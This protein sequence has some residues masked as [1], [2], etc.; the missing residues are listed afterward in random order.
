MLVGELSTF[1]HEKHRTELKWHRNE[2][3]NVDVFDIFYIQ[4]LYRIR[5]SI[6]FKLAMQG[7]H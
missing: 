6:M 4:S 5:L 1:F 3:S 7:A 2:V